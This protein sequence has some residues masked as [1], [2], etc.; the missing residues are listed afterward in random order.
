MTTSL[1]YQKQKLGKQKAEI[2]RSKAEILK[3]ES[4]NPLQL[5]PLVRLIAAPDHGKTEMRKAENRNRQPFP[6]VRLI[7]V[8]KIAMSSEDSC[9]N[10]WVSFGS[11][12]HSSRSSSSQSWLSS[13]S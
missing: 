8:V 11:T 6:F 4:R 7:I 12:A 2:A 13:A 3:T 5:L 10:G 9:S 1:I